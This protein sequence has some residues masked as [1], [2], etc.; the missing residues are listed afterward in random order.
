VHVSSP[1]RGLYLPD[2]QASHMVFVREKPA[3]HTQLDAGVPAASPAPQSRQVADP[4]LALYLPAAQT[5][6]SPSVP[7]D[8][9]LQT[10]DVMLALP[11]TEYAFTQN[12]HSDLSSAE[13]EPAAH[14]TQ[15]AADMLEYSPAPQSAHSRDSG[16]GRYL[17]ATHAV[18]FVCIPIEPALQ[19]QNVMFPLLATEYAFA[20][21]ERHS[22]LSSAEYEPAAHVTQPTVDMLEYSPA[23]QS[24][25]SRD[26]WVGM[27]L[28]ATHEVHLLCIPIQPALQMQDVIFPLLAAE[29]EFAG[30]E[31]HSD[32]SSAEYEPAAQ[33]THPTADVV[34]Y[35]PTPQPVH[36]TDPG[37]ALYVPGTQAS[38]LTL[39]PDHPDHPA[40]HEQS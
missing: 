22:D 8:P 30:H 38:Q 35:L 17:P 34:E 9:A 26:S 18:Q 5:V 19:M 31:R 37:L 36:S 16:V 12:R 3:M 15:P 33:Y 29:Y 25:H 2:T 21:H 40:L 28:P 4:G 10:Q 14:V 23:P 6:Q 7:V 11:A 13:Y 1:S 24:A 20:G 27:Y 39:A 32:L